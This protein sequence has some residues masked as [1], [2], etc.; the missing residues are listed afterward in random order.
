MT[1]RQ[2]NGGARF[3]NLHIRGVFVIR[4]GQFAAKVYHHVGREVDSAYSV[5]V[6]SC[7]GMGC[8][9]IFRFR[10]GQ[11]EKSLESAGTLGAKG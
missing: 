3:F 4:D 10:D 8:E 2:D 5:A 6:S 1:W 11:P 9:A 7:A